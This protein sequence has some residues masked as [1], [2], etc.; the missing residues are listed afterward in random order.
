MV[1]YSSCSSPSRFRSGI[2]VASFSTRAVRSMRVGIHNHYLKTVWISRYE[3]IERFR[4]S[5]A[6]GGVGTESASRDRADSLPDDLPRILVIPQRN[7]PDVPNMVRIGPFEKFKIRDK[8]RL[9]PDA[10]F[11]LRSGE[12]LS[13]PAAFL[14]WE[15]R[16]RA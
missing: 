13:P 11:H 9:N 15:V 6:V 2:P 3:I 4:Q 7:E 10:L 5:D 14:F 1:L 8:F 16:K 12:S